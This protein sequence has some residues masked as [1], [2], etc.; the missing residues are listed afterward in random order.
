MVE[1]KTDQENFWAG[2]FGTEYINR[3]DGDDYLAANLNFFG[4]IIA[5]TPGVR[6]IMEF[7]PNIGV[8]LRALELLLPNVHLAGVEINRDATLMLAERF[9]NGDFINES[10]LEHESVAQ[11]DLCLIKGV[12]IHLNPESL[13]RAYE[14]LNQASKRYVLIAE[15]YSRNPE[16][17]EYRGHGDRLFKRDFAGEF[18]DQYPEYELRD[19]GFAYHRDPN[20]SQDDVSW[21]L[22]EK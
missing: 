1:Y 3:N 21:F 18:L 6:S 10:F 15:Y 20:F 9:P 17:V 8:N 13:T 12:L 14:R 4:E 16:T 2:S 22:L 11:H 5:K 7:G 19:Y